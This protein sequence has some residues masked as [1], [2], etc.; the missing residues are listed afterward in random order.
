MWEYEHGVE[1]GADRG[2]LWAAWSDMAGW[3][4]WN[5]GIETIEIDGPFAKGTSF[6]MTPPGDD[7]VRLTL[8][9]IVP[10]EMFVDEMD[11]GD[12]TVRTIHRLDPLAD[13]R[14][15]VVYRTEI[16][17]PAAG[18]VGPQAGPAITGDFP[19]VV[20]ALIARAGSG[21]PAPDPDRPTRSARADDPRLVP[22]RLRRLVDRAVGAEHQ[23][24]VEGA[25]EPAVVRDPQHRAFEA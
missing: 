17:G 12:F 4:E 1:T 8:V 19:D 7:P 3:P 16:T 2:A 9:E 6:T 14:T 23:E 15:R 25:G 22:D 11:G 5:A 13:G 21:P 20:A 18:D 24:A 10:G